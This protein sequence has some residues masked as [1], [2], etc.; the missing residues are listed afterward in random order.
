MG[1]P[2]LRSREFQR[3]PPL[4]T[5]PSKASGAG[6]DLSGLCKPWEIWGHQEKPKAPEGIA[7][8]L[9]ALSERRT[10]TQK[11]CLCARSCSYA[12]TPGTSSKAKPM[13]PHRA[14]SHARFIR[15][16]ALPAG[17]VTLLILQRLSLQ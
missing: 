3:G 9:F 2:P 10:S 16:H 13:T 7:T 5:K 11:V 17:E 15:F 6:Y 14:K 12:R 4:S 1:P 8:E